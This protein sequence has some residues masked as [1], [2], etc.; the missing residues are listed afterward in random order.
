[1]TADKLCLAEELDGREAWLAALL[2]LLGLP[3][4]TPAALPAVL[5]EAEPWP[6]VLVLECGARV[7][8]AG[9]LGV[10]ESLLLRPAAAGGAVSA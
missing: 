5:M 4:D 2:L 3:P 1:M 7:A 10:W 9:A 8:A 6:A